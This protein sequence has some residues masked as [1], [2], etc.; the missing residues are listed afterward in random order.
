MTPKAQ[1]AI[2]YVI[3]KEGGYVNHPNDPGGETK[4]GISKRSYPHLDIKNLIKEEAFGIYYNDWWDPQYEMM[5]QKIS[6]RILDMSVN[7][8]KRTA[9]KL[10]QDA[11]VLLTG[12]L[13]KADGIIGPATMACYRK[14][15][16]DESRLLKEFQTLR[17]NYYLRLVKN[18]SKFKPFLKGW[19]RRAYA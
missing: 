1:R 15:K 5:S 9:H 3:H 10:L 11:L 13:I 7:S 2:E 19:L 12:C 16:Y 8:G 6:T 14:A 18:D 4:F 17:A